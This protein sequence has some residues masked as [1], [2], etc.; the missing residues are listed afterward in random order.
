MAELMLPKKA[1][2]T[3]SSSTSAAALES[4]RS[5]AS[6]AVL[7]PPSAYTLPLMQLHLEKHHC[8]VALS[9]G[10]HLLTIVDEP[11]QV[12]NHASERL[13]QICKTDLHTSVDAD[14]L[15]QQSANEYCVRIC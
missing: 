8:R 12:Q 6:T 15:S 2:R 14:M 9:T 1:S 5:S 7:S 4:K 13:W 11:L 10:W 3:S